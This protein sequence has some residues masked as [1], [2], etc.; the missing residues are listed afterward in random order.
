MPK[1]S[2]TTAK[3]H[4]PHH[5]CVQ[6]AAASGSTPVTVHNALNLNRPGKPIVRARILAALAARGEA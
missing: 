4:Y 6:I 2:S 5:V 1:K 3:H